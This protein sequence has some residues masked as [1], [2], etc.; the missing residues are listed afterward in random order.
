MR[1]S[2]R[3][4]LMR[5][6]AQSLKTWAEAVLLEAGEPGPP[7]APVPPRA[8]APRR[9]VPAAPVPREPAREETADG[10]PAQ[11][12]RD[13]QALRGGPPADWLKHARRSAGA[14]VERPVV[15][16]PSPLPV[17]EAPS[18][19][20]REVEVERAEPSLL[21]AEWKESAPRPQPL[22]GE[23]PRLPR[24][25]AG[26]ERLEEQPVVPRSEPPSPPAAAPLEPRAPLVTRPPHSSELRGEP[27]PARSVASAEPRVEAA[28]PALRREEP[29]PTPVS[30]SVAPSA[31]SLPSLP[32]R[33]SA[34][35]QL[36]EALAPL[37]SRPYAP[38]GNVM[39]PPA[40]QALA[41]RQEEP[42]SPAWPALPEPSSVQDHWPWPVLPEPPSTEAA[43]SALLLLYWERLNR[44]DREQRGE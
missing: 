10:P 32:A 17:V 15:P 3:V 26:R 44:L 33:R 7:E 2:L 19:E 11:W 24:G 16:E 38:V 18:E 28:A 36:V 6:V 31:E 30:E 20:S 5:A 22:R 25:P 8:A 27:P 37:P 14:P 4:L 12:L 40:S 23:W 42:P 13:V 21:P 34:P 35:A 29:A 39:A 43:D 9:E 1:N 41:S